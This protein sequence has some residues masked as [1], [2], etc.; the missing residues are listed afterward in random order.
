[1]NWKRS[2]FALIVIGATSLF[3]ENEL[4]KADAWEANESWTIQDEKIAVSSQKRTFLLPKD[5]TMLNE[6]EFEAD[7]TPLEAD[8]G[9][10]KTIGLALYTSPTEYWHFAFI[11]NPSGDKQ[12][13]ELKSRKDGVWGHESKIKLKCLAYQGRNLKLEYGKTY[14]FK[15][16]L[17]SKRIDGF[18]YKQDSDKV[19]AHMAF[20]INNDALKTGIPALICKQINAEFSNIKLKSK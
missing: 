14:K 2:I 12:F 3:A 18:I 11:D 6:M 5:K 8:G 9:S 16:V 1:M 7:I 4:A 15:L 17:S 19:L 10:W 13:V 20:T